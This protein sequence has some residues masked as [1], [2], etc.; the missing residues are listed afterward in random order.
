MG[1]LGVVERLPQLGGRGEQRG[2][3]IR[4]LHQRLV[5]YGAEIHVIR[6]LWVRGVDQRLAGERDELRPLLA[7]GRVVGTQLEPRRNPGKGAGEGLV[8]GP[9][10]KACFL[11]SITCVALP[12]RELAKHPWTK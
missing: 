6:R 1:P 11:A 5:G 2:S 3:Q 12:E 8:M 9:G 10:L 7:F 4:G